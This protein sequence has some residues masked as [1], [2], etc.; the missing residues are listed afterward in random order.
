[1]PVNTTDQQITIPIGADVADNPVAFINQVADVEPRLVRTY[2][3]EADRTARMLALSENDFSTL[4]AENRAEI[5][6]GTNHISLHTRSLYAQ[7]YKSATQ[8]LTPSSIALQSVTDLVTPVP[9]AGTFSFRGIIYYESGTTPDIKFAF[10]VPAGSILRW[11][12]L[13]VVPAGGSTGD[14]SFLT[15]TP[16]DGSISY[17]GAGIGTVLFCQIEGEYVAGGTAGN[18]QFRAAQNTSDPS[19]TSIIARSRI[20]MWRHL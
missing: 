2:T 20:E 16:S 12:G 6:N 8:I 1:M 9:A 4:A 3:N 14:A 5:Y 15:T 10:L 7:M 17:G 13:G 11:G 19:N 18:F